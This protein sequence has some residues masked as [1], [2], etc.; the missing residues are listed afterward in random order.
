MHRTARH[1]P[2]ALVRL[3][4]V[5]ALGSALSGVLA[6]RPVQAQQTEAPAAPP[7]AGAKPSEAAT[8][9][10]DW[11]C[12]QHKQPVLTA[13]QMWDGPSVEPEGKT[14]SDDGVR[15]MVTIVTSRRVP[16]E[17]V[18]RALASFRD[19]LPEAERDPKLT[20]LFAATLKEI[21]QRRTVVMDGIEKFQRRQVSRAKKLEEEGVELAALQKKAE[22]D[23]ALTGD[24]LE[25]QQRYDWDARV[26]QERQQNIPV[27]CEIPVLIEQRLFAVA[28]AIRAAM[29]N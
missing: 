21:N 9:Y 12:V 6:S 27:A 23:V 18:E 26:F 2:L 16:M 15:R 1:S 24:Y 8:G 13:A 22:A 28:Q 17:E 11:P 3:A 25:A 4:V 29:S 7:P 19:A 20:E 10:S 5:L 14:S